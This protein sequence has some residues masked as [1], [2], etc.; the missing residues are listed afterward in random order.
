MREELGL[1]EV[2]LDVLEELD[3][4][5][6]RSGARRNKRKDHE[7]TNYNEEY[8]VEASEEENFDRF[9]NEYNRC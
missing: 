9:I 5:R 2:E 7:R 3:F 1:Q 8:E 6:P 4:E